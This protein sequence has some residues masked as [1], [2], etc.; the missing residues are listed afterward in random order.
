MLEFFKSLTCIITGAARA[1]S[2]MIPFLHTQLITVASD[3]LARPGRGRVTSVAFAPNGISWFARYHTNVCIW[4]PDINSF[5]STFQYLVHE[6]ENNHP[7][8]DECLDFV[9]FGA[10]EFLLVRY[11]NG[12]TSMILP[13]N[14]AVR[15]Q[16]STELIQGIEE[17]LQGGWTIGN[18]TSLCGFDT[19]RWFIEW[20]RGGSAQFAYSTGLGE[21]TKQDLERI[22]KVL[23]GV[24]SNAAA[25][26]NNQTAQLVSIAR[27]RDREVTDCHRL[28]QTQSS[29][30][31][32]I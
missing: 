28:R 17:K 24:G 19:N 8:K 6:L 9:A 7:R 3:G 23:S 31:N 22:Q 12:N 18:R 16:I 1:P 15:S 30:S 20:K 13:Q 21:S 27:F 32:T 10:H 26:M 25:V 5:P 2:D 11:E 14:P 4:G 29:T